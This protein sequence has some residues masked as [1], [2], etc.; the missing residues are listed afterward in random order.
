MDGTQVQEQIRQRLMDAGP[1]HFR[2]GVSPEGDAVLLKL[3]AEFQPD[4]IVA[5]VD[6]ISATD[7]GWVLPDAWQ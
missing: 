3:L 7:P 6:Q 4:D 1:Q 5:A 2:G